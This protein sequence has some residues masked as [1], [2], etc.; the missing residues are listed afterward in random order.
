MADV[1]VDMDMD[2]VKQRRIFKIWYFFVAIFE[3]IAKH[4]RRTVFYST[5]KSRNR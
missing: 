1:D 5:N 3:N 4:S 2:A